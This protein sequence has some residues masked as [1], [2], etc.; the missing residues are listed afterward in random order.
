VTFLGALSIAGILFAV[1]LIIDG[2]VLVKDVMELFEHATQVVNPTG[3]FRW[4]NAIWLTGH[5]FSSV[6]GDVFAF[7]VPFL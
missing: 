1:D 5:D 7:I 3:L 4:L 6:A 2:V